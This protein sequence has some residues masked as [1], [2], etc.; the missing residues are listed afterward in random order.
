MQKTMP[1]IPN[2]ELSNPEVFYQEPIAAPQKKFNFTLVVI[3]P[4]DAYQRG[5]RI[6]DETDIETVIANGKL[7]CCAKRAR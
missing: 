2:P 1:E 3:N 7:T 5:Q 6:A 4:F